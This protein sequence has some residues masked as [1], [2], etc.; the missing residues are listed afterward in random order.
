M[1][2]GGEKR[3]LADL[4]IVVNELRRDWRAS[5]VLAR[6]IATERDRIVHELKC[7]GQSVI[8]LDDGRRVTVRVAGSGRQA[9]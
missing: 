3:V 2:S 6:A 1:G 4:P 8:T 9:G 7:S 5:E